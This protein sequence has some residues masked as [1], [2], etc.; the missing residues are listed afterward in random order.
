MVVDVGNVNNTLT[1]H[2]TSSANGETLQ[3]LPTD[4]Q[5]RNVLVHVLMM[6]T[7][8]VENAESIY[9]ASLVNMFV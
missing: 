4:A 1:V 2:L 6:F 9:Y 8:S 3:V 5:T 7:V